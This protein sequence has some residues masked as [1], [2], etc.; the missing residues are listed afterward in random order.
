[1]KPPEQMGGPPEQ[2]EEEPVKDKE[3]TPEGPTSPEPYNETE[4]NKLKQGEVST[5]IYLKGKEMDV[6]QEEL[7]QFAKDVIVKELEKENYTFVYGFRKLTGIE[8]AEP[9]EAYDEKAW[10]KLKQEGGDRPAFVIAKGYE[11][12]VS[13]DELD[14]FAESVLS[15]EMQNQNYG[16]VYRFRKDMG[17]GT[18]EEIRAAGEQAY[19][20]FLERGDHGSATSIAENL[21]GRDSEEW[22]RAFVASE[23]ELKKTEERRKRKERKEKEIEDEERELNATISK[24][25]TFTDLFNA[26]ND[27][28]EKEGL[29][30]LHFE[31]ELWDNFDPEIVEE[32]LAFREVQASKAAT[33]K[34]LDFF[35]ERGYSQIDV[36]TFLPIKFKREQKKKQ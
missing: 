23:A 1:M 30:E 15:R 13:K 18:E 17:I 8:R 26:I 3:G 2:P 32:I 10:E 28:E 6:P 31:E 14:R 12:S 11:T 21:Y 9:T 27:I 20:V 24:D 25:A 36:S 29:G 19:K 35:N 34:V 4:W 22:R 16:L 7:D 33:T 5:P